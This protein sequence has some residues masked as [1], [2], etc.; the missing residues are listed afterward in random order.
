MW[1][2][3]LKAKIA[4][5]KIT[6]ANLLYEGSITIDEDWMD[7]VGLFENEQVHIVNLNN[8]E[9]FVTYVIKGERGSKTIALNGPAARKGLIGDFL[10]II[11]Y[12]QIDPALET[13]EPRVMHLEHRPL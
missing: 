12:A 4:Y 11:A 10:H 3:T 13:L 7:E 1:I 9:R 6:D 2:T 5:A 8:G